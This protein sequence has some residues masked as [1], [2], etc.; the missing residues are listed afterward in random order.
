M[1]AVL[2]STARWFPR[3]TDSI[4]TPWPVNTLGRY[5]RPF[6]DFEVPIWNLK[7]PD[8]IVV[9]VARAVAV[10]RPWWQRIGDAVGS[11]NAQVARRTLRRIRSPQ[12]CPR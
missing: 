7:L 10:R 8:S 3:T 11:L 12:C 9:G 5:L 1:I 2:T 4:A 6:C